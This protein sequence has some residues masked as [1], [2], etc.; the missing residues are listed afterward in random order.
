MHMLKIIR[1]EGL[2]PY[3]AGY[4]RQQAEAAELAGHAE[5]LAK[6]I[7]LQHAPVYTL[8]R[9]TKKEHLLGLAYD[10]DDAPAGTRAALYT[11][12]GG[13]QLDPS[14]GPSP[15]RLSSPQALTPLPPGER[16][17]VVRRRWVS[18]RRRFSTRG[19]R[20]KLNSARNARPI[21][22]C[23]PRTCFRRGRL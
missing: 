21:W 18:H 1:L 4:A 2:V 23:S 9:T 10:E 15:A 6:L 22:R 13:Q 16:G 19:K 17:T 14:T 11:K 5:P 12:A 8:G 7:L 3:A 20:W